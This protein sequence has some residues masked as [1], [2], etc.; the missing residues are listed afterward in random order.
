M[1]ERREESR[2]PARSE[3][4]GT[5]MGL[6]KDMWEQLQLAG[7]LFVDPRV[8]IFTKLIPVATLGYFVVPLDLLPDVI[9]GLG[10]L[11]DIAL[12]A[13]GV[14]FFINVCPPDIV[15]EHRTAIESRQRGEVWSPPK[16]VIDVEAR[17]PSDE[18]R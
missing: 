17:V 3:D 18:E 14:K 7:R 11:D 13:L 1:S 12:I 10:Q 8:P 15:A 4:V 9:L 6:L 5:V 16:D 2:P